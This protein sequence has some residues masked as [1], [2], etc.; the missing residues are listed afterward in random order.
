ML[1]TFAKISLIVAG[2]VLL[3]PSLAV[4]P[5]MAEMASLNDGIMCTARGKTPEGVK[6]Y[7]YTSLIDN[8]SI[9]KKQPVSVTMVEPMTDVVAGELIVIDKKSQTLIIDDFDAAT[10]PEMQPVG[11]AMTTYQGK[12]TFSGMS[13]AGTPVSF[14]LGNNYS[15]FTIKHGNETYMGVC[16]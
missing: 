8:T 12:D 1:N 2:T 5:T 4:Q 11:S 6:I 15:A 3:V 14:T 13:K 16:H 10:S 9:D 7:L